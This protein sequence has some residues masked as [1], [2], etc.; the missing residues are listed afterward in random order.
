MKMSFQFEDFFLVIKKEFEDFFSFFEN[1]NLNNIVDY[2][3]TQLKLKTPF[4]L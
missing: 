3:N 4:I 1:S 2:Y